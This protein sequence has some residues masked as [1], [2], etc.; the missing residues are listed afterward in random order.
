MDDL[1]IE[2]GVD[3]LIGLALLIEYLRRAWCRDLPTLSDACKSQPRPT[4]AS[5]AVAIAEHIRDPLLIAVL[6]PNDFTAHPLPASIFDERFERRLVDA[7]WL[8]FRDRELPLSFFG[9][10]HQ[11]CA[12]NPLVTRSNDSTCASTRR[13]LGMFYTPAPIVDYL[14][15]T[16]LVTCLQSVRQM[17]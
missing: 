2:Q 7:T 16:S 1:I 4:I 13:A 8:L 15:W 12:G 3:D 5:I 14:V 6:N 11:L 10:F 9:D 17:N